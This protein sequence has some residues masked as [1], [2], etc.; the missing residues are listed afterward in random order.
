MD[1]PRQTGCY[2]SEQ[3]GQIDPITERVWRRGCILYKSISPEMEVAL[4]YK[5]HT[6]LVNT[7][8]LTMLT[9][10]SLRTHW[11]DAYIYC[12]MFRLSAKVTRLY[13]FNK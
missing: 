7:V 12:Y 2:R 9:L 6:L 5:L 10:L 4:R 8:S 3:T 1:S 11:H 13:C